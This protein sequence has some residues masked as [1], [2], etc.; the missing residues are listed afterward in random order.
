ML[1]GLLLSFV[2]GVTLA[3]PAPA[4]PILLLANAGSAPS[5]CSE[6]Y[7]LAEDF[8]LD[9]VSSWSFV[10]PT[11]PTTTSTATCTTAANCQTACN[12]AGAQVTF[13][14]TWGATNTWID[15]TG[16]DLRFIIDCDVHIGSI[17]FRGSRA[18]I[19]SEMGLGNRCDNSTP[20]T[21]G[22]IYWNDNTDDVHIDGVDVNSDGNFNDSSSGDVCFMGGNAGNDRAAI[23]NVRAQC[24]TAGSLFNAISNLVFFNVVWMSGVTTSNPGHPDPDNVAGWTFRA[25]GGGPYAIVNSWLENSLFNTFRLHNAENSERLLIRGSTLINKGEGRIAIL[26]YD[27]LGSVTLPSA[28]VIIEDSRIYGHSSTNCGGTQLEID[29]LAASTVRNNQFFNSQLGTS[30]TDYSQSYLNTQAASTGTHDW[31]VGNTFA[32]WTS[33]PAYPAIGS[34]RDV[35]PQTGITPSFTGTDTLPTTGGA[36]TCTGYE[37]A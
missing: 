20:A 21:V 23:T 15:C 32:D 16:T 31:S 18:R 34:P 11:A 4:A 13:T 26:G 12:V 14:T 9:A 2:F 35:I 22:A 7:P 24:A 1:A 19:Q 37:D 8:C 33:F 3:Q 36:I 17:R 10:A 6:T 29:E 5:E 30:T 27:Q 28:E 25:T